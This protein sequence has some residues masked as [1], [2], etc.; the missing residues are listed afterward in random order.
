MLYNI[1]KESILKNKLIKSKGEYIGIPMPFKRL[2]NYIPLSCERGQSIGILGATGSG[3][4]RFTRWL[5]IY[6]VYKFYKETGYPLKVLFFPLEDSKE[7]VMRNMI[8]HYMYELYG[9]YINLQELDSKGGRELPDF[10]VD[11]LAKAEGFFNEFEQVVTVIDGLNKPTEIFNF[12][13]EYALRT[14]KIEKYEI[15]VNGKKEKQLRYIP[16]NNIHTIVIV[17]NMSNIDIEDGKRDEREA[18]VHF[19]KNLVRGRLCNFFNFTVIQV[20]QQDFQSE[21]QS[22]NRDGETMISKLEPSLA[23]VGDSKT[24]T[25]SMH[26]VLGIFHPARF[27]II[28]YPPITKYNNKAYK[29]D[30]LGNRFR[31]LHV[32][33]A[34]DVDFGQK[35]AFNFEAVSE[36]MSELPDLGSQ[37][38]EDMYRKIQ[39][40][41]PTKF[42][43]VTNL[44]F[45]EDEDLEEAPF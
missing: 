18:I 45:D 7:K 31:S 44:K 10:V 38:L 35:V 25:R 11:K 6:N 34:N 5:Y 20:L 13:Q 30:I 16:N 24:I 33:K 36:I 9:I 37:E 40:K 42:T 32:L 12:C 19:C 4:S 8:C 27:N 21:R 29:L 28:A 1:V 39:D 41:N 23:G 2:S 17:D 3:K 14:G 26:L 43:K 22:F 15:E